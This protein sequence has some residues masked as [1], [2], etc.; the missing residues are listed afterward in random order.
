MAEITIYKIDSRNFL[1]VGTEQIEISNYTVKSS[2]NGITELN[3]T[4]NGNSNVFGT[5]ASL[6][7]PQ[8]LSL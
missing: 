8:K 2:A 1:Q 3:V 7:E 4:I 6:E 5:S